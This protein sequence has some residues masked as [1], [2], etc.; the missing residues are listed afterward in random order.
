MTDNQKNSAP[1][2]NFSARETVLINMGARCGRCGYKDHLAALT[3][4]VEGLTQNRKATNYAQYWLSV[5]GIV[6]MDPERIEVICR[7]CLAIEQEEQR[8]QPAKLTGKTLYVY[9]TDLLPDQINKRQQFLDVL[10]EPKEIH[11]ITG[12]NEVW[13]YKGD[14]HKGSSWKVS[15]VSRDLKEVFA[16]IDIS[17]AIAINGLFRIVDHKLEPIS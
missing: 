6:K 3:V 14:T 4:R 9:S 8:E 13:K 2:R 10:A 5:L 12:N 16:G 11:I 15:F 17:P 7:N 1:P